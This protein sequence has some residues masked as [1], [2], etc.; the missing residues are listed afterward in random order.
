MTIRLA[1]AGVALV[2]VGALNLGGL[3]EIT[4]AAGAVALAASGVSWLVARRGGT[5]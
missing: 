5:S 2:A 3:R 4:I 1:L